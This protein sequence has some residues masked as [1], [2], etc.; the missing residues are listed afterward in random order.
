MAIYD[1]NQNKSFVK[2]E[3]LE[4]IRLLMKLSIIT[5]NY[6]NRSGLQKTADSVVSQTFKDFEWIVIDG[7]SSDGSRDLIEL[8]KNDITYWVSE[9]DNGIY[10]AMNKGV[11]RA[12]GDYC[13]FLNSGDR[14][15]NMDVIS[16]VFPILDGTDFISG[17]E[18]HVDAGYSYYKTNKN[19]NQVSDYHMLVGILWHQ[20]TFIRTQ[21]LKEHPYDESLKIAADWEEM[22]YEFI[23]NKRSYKHI[24][25]IV[26]DFV[27]GGASEKDWNLLCSEREMVRNKYLSR[28]QQDEIAL[29][30][31]DTQDSEYSKRYMSELAYTAFANN[32]YSQ[33][34]YLDIFL[35]Y[36]ETLINYSSIHHRFFNCLCLCGRMRF[37]KLIYRWMLFK[38]IETICSYGN[39]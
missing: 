23:F 30:F 16:T 8:H 6:N 15:H 34:E 21:L 2:K 36:R 10:N 29:N 28:R 11:A 39:S 37:A 32:F 38:N 9:P 24:D 3:Y 18:W 27:V 31:H 13:L 4:I 25:I 19:P 35:P 22:F 1:C 33:Q 14:L 12:N 20:C 26:S 5:I 17:D 7:G